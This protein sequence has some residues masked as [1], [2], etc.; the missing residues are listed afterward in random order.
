MSSAAATA[1]A[2]R[3]AAALW[4]RGGG[5]HLNAAAAA[6]HT[7]TASAHSPLLRL[8]GEAGGGL[9]TTTRTHNGARLAFS[10]AAHADAR[11]RLVVARTS[12][13]LVPSA[14][15]PS[16]SVSSE[17]TSVELMFAV[18]L[19]RGAARHR[20]VRRRVPRRRR[21]RSSP[22][23]AGARHERA[24]RARHP[25]RS[26]ETRRVPLR[27]PGTHP[28]LLHHRPHRPWQVHFGR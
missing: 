22:R 13:E 15:P 4:W 6:H 21:P 8:R 7:A 10:V 17:S 26:K 5:W 20:V 27:P 9:R 11:N 16:C 14:A 3:R 25:R 12:Y 1:R 23:R 2:A 28:Q 24:Y 18:T 19:L